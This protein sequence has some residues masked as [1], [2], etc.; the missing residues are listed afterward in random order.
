M[1]RRLERRWKT[2][3]HLFVP[4]LVLGAGSLLLAGCSSTATSAPC[5][6]KQMINTLEH[7]PASGSVTVSPATGSVTVSPV[8]NLPPSHDND[9]G[10]GR[11]PDIKPDADVDANQR[12]ALCEIY[13][14]EKHSTR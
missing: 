12:Q 9:V 2:R 11:I 8:V 10:D 14:S 13:R 6:L 4:V 7:P 5:T 3:T 1:R